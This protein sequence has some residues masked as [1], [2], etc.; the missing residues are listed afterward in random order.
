MKDERTDACAACG[1]GDGET[2]DYW[3]VDY[4][5]GQGNLVMAHVECA[6]GRG[7]SRA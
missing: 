3:L 2:E 4:V 5:N 7:W 1:A 6:E